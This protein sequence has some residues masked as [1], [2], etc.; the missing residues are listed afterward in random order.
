MRAA[1]RA[2]ARS[3]GP[4]VRLRAMRDVDTPQRAT[5][6]L[7]GRPVR[8]MAAKAGAQAGAERQPG[9]LL[10]M[11]LDLSG[12]EVEARKNILRALKD[13][14]VREKRL[15]AEVQRLRGQLELERRKR[16]QEPDVA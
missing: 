7:R 5:G 14:Y 12:L 15:Q 8:V 2:A 16:L 9:T 4:L 13:S 1:I 6:P 10:S 3:S 11:F